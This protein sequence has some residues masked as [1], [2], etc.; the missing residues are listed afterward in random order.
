MKF[1]ILSLNDVTESIEKQIKNLFNQLN[2]DIKQQSISDVLAQGNDFV[3][4]CCWDNNSLVGMASMGTYKVISGH[5]GI[6]EDVV[7]SSNYRGKGL[8]RK[9]MNI[10]I[11]EGKQLNLTEVL[12]FTGHH[13]KPAITLYKSLGFNQK[14]S[15]MYVLKL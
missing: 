6:V 4:V 10:L 9:L 14:E 5:K 12:L 15:G 3:C 8:G 1:N 7:V 11:E 13:R 2:S